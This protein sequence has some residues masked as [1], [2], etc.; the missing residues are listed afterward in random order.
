MPILP[1][2]HLSLSLIV[3]SVELVKNPRKGGKE[4]AQ[5]QRHPHHRRELKRARMTDRGN[6]LSH[7][8]MKLPKARTIDS[9][10]EALPSLYF[11]EP[12]DKLTYPNQSS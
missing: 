5:V 6:H 8:S 7:R 12:I 10:E 9:F 3:R 2:L 11:S 4:A 1:P